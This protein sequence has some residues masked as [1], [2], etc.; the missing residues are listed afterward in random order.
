L[1]S[2]EKSL[3]QQYEHQKYSEVDNFSYADFEL[4]NVEISYKF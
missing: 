4:K 1:P 2:K 3:V